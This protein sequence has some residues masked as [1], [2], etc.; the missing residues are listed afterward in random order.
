[1]VYCFK[2]VHVI[3]FT[4]ETTIAFT[5]NTIVLRVPIVEDAYSKRR[6][7]FEMIGLR[8]I[9]QTTNGNNEHLM[10][11]ILNKCLI[12]TFSF[13]QRNFANSWN[14]TLFWRIFSRHYYWYYIC[15]CSTMST[16]HNQRMHEGHRE[17]YTNTTSK[18]IANPKQTR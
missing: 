16:L 17:E 18:S 6:Y 13:G 7:I 12:T 14:L 5:W 15:V 1:M 2:N 3:H 10:W 11:Y 4:L 9:L 8:V